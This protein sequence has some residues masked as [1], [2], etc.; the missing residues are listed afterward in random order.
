MVFSEILREKREAIGLSQKQ[1]EEQLGLNRGNISKYEKG[2]SKPTMATVVKM[3]EYF[4]CSVDELLGLKTL[5]VK[6]SDPTPGDTKIRLGLKELS[7]EDFEDISLKDLD[8]L[9]NYIENRLG[10]ELNRTKK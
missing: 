7:L 4:G 5:S 10:V 3:A 8:K 9:L 2:E 1:L 6:V